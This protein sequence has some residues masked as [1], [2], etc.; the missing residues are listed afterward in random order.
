ME[1]TKLT[2]LHTT[3]EADLFAGRL[4]QAGIKARTAKAPDRP[5]AF[6]TAYGNTGGPIEV[7]VPVDEAV[8]ARKLLDSL[9]S[10]EHAPPR[11]SSHRTVQL[12]GRGL[13]IVS[14]VGVVAALLSAALR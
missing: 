12:V 11:R 10:S 7:F 14:L 8:A 13:L 9:S 3:Y 5:A 2:T 6:L 4:Q 1:W